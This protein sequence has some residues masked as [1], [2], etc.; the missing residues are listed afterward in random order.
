MT[1]RITTLVEKMPGTRGLFLGILELCSQEQESWDIDN[2]ILDQLQYYPSV[3]TPVEFRAMLENAGALVFLP[4]EED[5]QGEE[6]PGVDDETATET[7]PEAAVGPV[8]DEEGYLVVGEERSGSWVTSEDGKAFL[9][10]I[11]PRSQLE[12]LFEAEPEFVDIYFSILELCSERPHS[13]SE[14]D[15]HLDSTL[16]ALKPRRYTS[17][18]L[19]NLEK[20]DA[21]RWE[22]NWITTEFGKSLL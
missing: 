21:V 3:Y 1:M 18:F 12:E 7:K 10:S 16:K 17:F 14:L 13:L 9:A 5:I 20:N 15:S 6:S 2:Y 19:E 4:D 11:D 22:R 8:I